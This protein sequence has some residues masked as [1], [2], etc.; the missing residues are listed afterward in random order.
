MTGYAP[1]SSSEPQSPTQESLT[2]TTPTSPRETDDQGPLLPK[3]SPEPEEDALLCEAPP[4]IQETSVSLSQHSEDPEFPFS[5]S[6]SSSSAVG[7]SAEAGPSRTPF[8]PGGRDGV[9]ANMAAKPTTSSSLTPGKTYEDIEPPGYTEVTGVVDPS[10]PAPP[11]VEETLI[12]SLVESGD[13]LIDGLPVGNMTSFVMTCF[14][15]ALFDFLGYFMTSILATS[16]A[17]KHGARA[18]LGITLIRIGLLLKYQM[19]HGHYDDDEPPLPSPSPETSGHSPEDLLPGTSREPNAEDGRDFLSLL[20][21]GIG[22]FLIFKA[23]GDF[24]LLKQARSVLLSS[25]FV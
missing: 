16:H 7:E 6:S 8:I 18:G 5:S 19:S 3:R 15:S 20:F 21:I 24:L 25:G 11:Y 14:I 13:V 10:D 9:F 23:N 1:V 12:T 2:P 22:A 4:P 17:N